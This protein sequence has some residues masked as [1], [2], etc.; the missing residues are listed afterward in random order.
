[1]DTVGGLEMIL[2]SDIYTVVASVCVCTPE[3]AGRRLPEYLRAMAE[4]GRKAETLR[5]MATAVRRCSEALARLGVE[6]PE[7]VEPEDVVVMASL[8]G[9]AESSRRQWTMCMGGYLLWATGRD[10]VKRARLLWNA[11]DGE[12]VWITAE[13]YRRMMEASGPRD[14]LVLALGATMGLRRSEIA[15]LSLSDVEGG[16]VAVMGK[17][18]GSGKAVDKPMSEAV[19]RELRAYLE[20]RPASESEAL[21]VST[22]GGRLTEAGVYEAIKRAGARAGV[23]VTPHSLRRLYAMTL[24]DAGVDLE[25]MARMMRHESPMTTM[26]CYLKADPRRISEAQA[27]VDALLRLS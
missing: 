2:D 15:G 18:H 13:E 21:L 14:R 7:D 27:K 25:T 22:K 9:G 19:R 8:I 26:R 1:M 11:S 24:A 10:V 23:E 16:S 20:V 17:G 4:R 5:C 6:D 3:G 12:K